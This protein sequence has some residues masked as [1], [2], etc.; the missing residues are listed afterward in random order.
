MT[1]EQLEAELERLKTVL[2]R[3][4]ATLHDKKRF[5]DVLQRILQNRGDKHCIQLRGL[6]ASHPAL[7]LCAAEYNTTYF[8]EID[9]NTPRPEAQRLGQSAWLSTLPPL[10]TA[11][12][13]SDFI[14][15]VSFGIARDIITPDK[16]MRLLYAAQIAQANYRI[17]EK[18]KAET[19]DRRRGPYRK[20]READSGQNS[21][22]KP[23]DNRDPETD[24]DSGSNQAPVANPDVP[25][26]KGPEA[27]RENFTSI[28]QSIG[29]KK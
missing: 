8:E 3:P 19:A 7:Y 23:A 16:G 18:Q 15:C 28:L 24:S 13:I 25:A 1:E 10:D 22:V 4:G 14:T 11:Q 9:A 17:V 6:A 29:Y 12:S 21:E 27:I 5:I 2:R 26:K 20:T